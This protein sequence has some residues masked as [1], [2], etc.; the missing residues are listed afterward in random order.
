M[1]CGIP[2]IGNREI[3][4]MKNIIT[5]SGGGLLADFNA[6][7]FADAMIALA[8][9]KELAKTMGEKGREW[10]IKNRSYIQMAKYVEEIY[11]NKLLI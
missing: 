8:K 3:F 11:F 5:K 7:S 6:K 4:D 9:K 1:A 10:V 2:A